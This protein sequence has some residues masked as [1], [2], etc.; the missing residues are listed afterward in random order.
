MDS[1]ESFKDHLF[2]D[3]ILPLPPRGTMERMLKRRRAFR[4]SLR[5]IFA[6]TAFAA[7]AVHVCRRLA[8]SAVVSDGRALFQE[9]AVLFF[10]LLFSGAW[11][12]IEL[13]DS[14]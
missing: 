1:C 10:A 7:I 12:Y 9:F 5:S 6:V 4:L 11:A 14:P 8:A 2:D 13:A 3:S